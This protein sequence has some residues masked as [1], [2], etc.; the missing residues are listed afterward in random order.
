MKDLK[1]HMR[2]AGEVTYADAHKD[3]KNEGFVS[4]INF[5]NSIIMIIYIY[6]FFK[7]LFETFVK[8]CPSQI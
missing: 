1:D 7:Y 2:S 8:L 6:H 5:I 3:H 4:N